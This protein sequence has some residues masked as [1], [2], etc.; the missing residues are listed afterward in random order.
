[1]REREREGLAKINIRSQEGI[2]KRHKISLN[3]FNR[4]YNVPR[5]TCITHL[6]LCTAYILYFFLYFF[7]LLLLSSRK[8]LRK[9]EANIM[10]CHVCVA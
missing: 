4:L 7:S 6:C 1:M 2:E 9:K 10:Q 5:N 8:D 3:T